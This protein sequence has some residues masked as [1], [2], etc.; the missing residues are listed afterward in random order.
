VT[1]KTIIK[2]GKY[3]RKIATKINDRN[4]EYLL[5]LNWL[6]NLNNAHIDRYIKGITVI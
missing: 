6:L 5:L 1:P 4:I 3:I 2:I